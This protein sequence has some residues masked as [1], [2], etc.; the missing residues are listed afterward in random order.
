M[1]NFTAETLQVMAEKRDRRLKR[2]AHK[3][4]RNV[5]NSNLDMRALWDNGL[6]DGWMQG[7]FYEQNIITSWYGNP[8]EI[9][10]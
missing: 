5:M 1:N 9:P 10:F 7:H 6:T 8:D 2:I 4:G 3:L